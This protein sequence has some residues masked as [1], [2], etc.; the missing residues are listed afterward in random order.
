MGLN[1]KYKIAFI[2]AGYMSREHIKVF[3]AQKNKF[4]IEGIISRKN[5]TAKKIAKKF[6]IKHLCTSIEELY[7]STKAL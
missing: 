4:S 3:K 6:K 2:G 1:K 7:L 5:I